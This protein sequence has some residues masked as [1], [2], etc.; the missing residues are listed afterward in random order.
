MCLK[1]ILLARL[2]AVTCLTEFLHWVVSQH[3]SIFYPLIQGDREVL[4][5]LKSMTFMTF[6][7]FFFYYRVSWPKWPWQK[8]FL[9]IC[10]NGLLVNWSHVCKPIFSLYINGEM[11]LKSC[12]I[13]ELVKEVKYLLSLPIYVSSTADQDGNFNWRCYLCSLSFVY[14]IGCYWVENVFQVWELFV[15]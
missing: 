7:F 11:F 14:K 10:K 1:S 15:I 2:P 13:E 5:V 4:F 9:K 12:L 8:A 3:C 6:F